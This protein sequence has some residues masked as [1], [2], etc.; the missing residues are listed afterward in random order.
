MSIPNGIPSLYSIIYT[1]SFNDPMSNLL[2]KND[3]EIPNPNLLGP[4][5]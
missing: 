3:V 5:A 1:N 4:I 2:L